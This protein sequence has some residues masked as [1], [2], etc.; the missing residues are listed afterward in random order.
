MGYEYWAPGLYDILMEYHERYAD[1]PLMVTEAGI[2]TEV[3]RR[4]AEHVT[5]T[6]EQIHFARR[7]GADVRGYYHWT[8]M[9]NFEWAEGYEPRFGLYRVDR[10]GEYARVPTEG[11][12]L[13]GE[14]AGARR[15]TIEQRETYGGLGPMTPEE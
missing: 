1:L 9:D 15:L 6:L 7:A 5:R 2:A 4:R 11:A 8:L 3:G 12:T 10:A 13:F 14:I